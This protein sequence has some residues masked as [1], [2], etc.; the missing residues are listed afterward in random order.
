[1]TAERYI[2]KDLGFCFYSISNHPHKFILYLIKLLDGSSE[3]AQ[4]AWNYLNDS[5]RLD[6]ALRY[7]SQILACAAIYMALR[8]TGTVIPTLTEDEQWWMIVTEDF[9]LI[10]IICEEILSLYDRPK[11]SYHLYQLWHLS[12]P[13]YSLLG[14]MDQCG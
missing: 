9:S 5:C 10:E 1:M 7:E 12:I 2:L 11:V 6:L 4:I 3:L 14:H 13:F 8:V